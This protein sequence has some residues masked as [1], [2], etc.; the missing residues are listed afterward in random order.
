MP[1]SPA[2]PSSARA[3]RTERGHAGRALVATERVA[4]ARAAAPGPRRR[5][6]RCAGGR[7]RCPDG[8]VRPRC[9]L[10]RDRGRAVPAQCPAP[11]WPGRRHRQRVAGDP[12]PASQRVRDRGIDATV[13]H[14]REHEDATG[15]RGLRPA[16]HLRPTG[17]RRWRGPEVASSCTASTGPRPRATPRT[18]RPAP[19]RPRRSAGS[20]TTSRG[21]RPTGGRRVASRPPAR[22]ARASRRAPST[23]SAPRRWHPLRRRRSGS[24]DGHP[25]TRPTTIA[26]AVRARAALRRPHGRD[27]RAGRRR[28]P[29]PQRARGGAARRPGWSP[30]PARGPPRSRRRTGPWSRGPSRRWRT[31]PPTRRRPPTRP[32]EMRCQH[33]PPGELACAAGTSRR[34]DHRHER[35]PPVRRGPTQACPHRPARATLRTTAAARQPSVTAHDG[36]EH[37]WQE[38]HHEAVAR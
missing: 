31:T 13:G 23:A 17:R 22:P 35:R 24:H 9:P 19:R 11:S 18:A 25:P 38:R 16:R 37:P 5:G 29:P 2:A 32:H 14:G 7:R 6:R 26:T 8:A 21:A 33:R 30:T 10:R 20:R 12:G 3:V 15:R 1:G 4:P 27:P 34:R 28:T 36:R